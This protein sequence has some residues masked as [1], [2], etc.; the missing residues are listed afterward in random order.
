MLVSPEWFL[1]PPV[2][3][4][5]NAIELINPPMSSPHALTRTGRP[6]NGQ[7]P[8][9]RKPAHA[10]PLRTMSDHGDADSGLH[11]FDVNFAGVRAAVV[12]IDAFHGEDFARNGLFKALQG[13]A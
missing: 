2:C 6:D 12:F 8:L 4:H 11:A 5:H 3:G 10:R 9:R 13:F 7:R 1:T